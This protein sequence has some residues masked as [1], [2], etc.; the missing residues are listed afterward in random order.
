MRGVVPRFQVATLTLTNGH[1]QGLCRQQQFLWIKY[2]CHGASSS[3]LADWTHEWRGPVAQ[4]RDIY[5]VLFVGTVLLGTTRLW[6]AGCFYKTKGSSE[7]SAAVY[8]MD[9][10]LKML[11]SAWRF[12]QTAHLDHLKTDD[13]GRPVF[14]G[15]HFVL[16]IPRTQQTEMVV[17][18]HKWFA[19][20]GR[21]LQN[22]CA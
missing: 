19:L 12:A 6:H 2:A 10:M 9:R 18:C 8:R 14:S 22:C 17:R 1:V 11:E 16:R 7:F 20:E 5:A 21:I 4:K 3:F 15:C 13:T